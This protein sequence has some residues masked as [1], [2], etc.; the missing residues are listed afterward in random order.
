MSEIK[1][2]VSLSSRFMAAIRAIETERSDRCVDI[3]PDKSDVGGI[4]AHQ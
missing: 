4:S 3:A 2:F 1:D